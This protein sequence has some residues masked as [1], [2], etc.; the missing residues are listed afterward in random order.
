MFYS[1]K[2]K[3]NKMCS[4]CMGDPEYIY[5]ERSS[6]TG[7]F[8]YRD[9]RTNKTYGAYQSATAYSNG[10][11]LV[12]VAKKSRKQ[13]YIDLD[14]N[15]SEEYYHALPYI[16]GFAQVHPK[17]KNDGILF[18]RDM[19]GRV[20]SEKTESGSDLH[21]F[22]SGYITLEEI[23]AIHFSDPKFVDAVI[24]ECSRTME[25]KMG[26]LEYDSLRRQTKHFNYT[27]VQILSIIDSKKKEATLLSKKPRKVKDAPSMDGM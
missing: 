17:M 8:H 21:K 23:P 12:R 20:T 22:Y 19:A 25:V 24:K 10:F 9:I 18:Y 14:G 4:T 26:K 3:P 11:G 2:Y 5:L 6:D 7:I 13:Q 16:G 27:L 1:N 15:L